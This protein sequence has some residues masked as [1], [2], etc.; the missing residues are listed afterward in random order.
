MKKS[1]EAELS[2]EELVA[3]LAS[4]CARDS[5]TKAEIVTYLI[6]VE[7]RRLHLRM[8]CSSMFD[9]CTRKVKMSKNTAFLRIAA[10]RLARRHPCLLA[11]ITRGG[12][13]LST[14]MLLRNH[15]TESNAEDLLA[16]VSGK[17]FREVEVLLAARAPKPDI[18]A[19]LVRLPEQATFPSAA[20]A[21]APAPRKPAARIAP[22]SPSRFALHVT[23]SEE[24]HDK[25]EHAKELMRHR[26]PNG[27]IEVIL[28]CALN[29]LLRILKKERLG[30]VERPRRGRGAKPGAISDGTR[31]EVFERDGEQCTFVASNGDRCPARGFLELDH[32]RARALGGN[33]DPSNVRV[34]C[35]PH[36]RF[37]AEEV[38][39]R[40]HVERAID[41]G[42]RESSEPAG[43]APSTVAAN[44]IDSGRRESS[45]PASE[46]SSPVTANSIDSGRRECLDPRPQ[47][48]GRAQ[49]LAGLI[50]LGF[51]RGEA[52][53]AL[54]AVLT[55]RGRAPAGHELPDVLREAL[56]ILT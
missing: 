11:A 55:R 16:V 6:E 9:F 46:G 14:L 15:L 20:G 19:A 53:R 8:A 31:R 12:L 3:Q 2:D 26:N 50:H 56:G 25:L 36:N 22:L 24:I 23:V 28:D 5:Q 52:T 17:S 43:A 33:G 51:M 4:L 34:L 7:E 40:E 1:N 32:V 48:D 41:S 37:H 42:R 10:A 21:S 44:D 35:R 29:A 13:H 27:D 30:N 45:E 47:T 39:G 18:V 54:D 38:F 49:A